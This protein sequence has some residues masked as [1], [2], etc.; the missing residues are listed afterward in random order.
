MYKRGGGEA[1]GGATSDITGAV[2]TDVGSSAPEHPIDIAN[3]PKPLATNSMVTN[4]LNKLRVVRLVSGLPVS[5]HT[6]SALILIAL[7]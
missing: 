7:S 4:R 2:G 1:S 3:E 5:D 6:K